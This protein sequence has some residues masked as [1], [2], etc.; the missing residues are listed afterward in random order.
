MTKALELARTVRRLQ[1]QK[2]ELYIRELSKGDKISLETHRN[3]TRKLDNAWE[4]LLI[5][6][7]GTADVYN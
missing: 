6:L 5:E 7:G 3:F 1:D 4:E 2:T